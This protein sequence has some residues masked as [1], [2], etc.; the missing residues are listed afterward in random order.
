MPP[1]AP[2]PPPN[3]AGDDDDIIEL[4]EIVEKGTLG[5]SEDDD[6]FSLDDN[7]V[8]ISF[9]QELEELFSEDDEDAPRAA[10]AGPKAMDADAMD[11]DAMDMGALGLDDDA[12]LGETMDFSGPSKTEDEDEGEELLGLD[13][14]TVDENTG[15]DFDAALDELSA[16][17][18]AGAEAFGEQEIDLDSTLAFDEDLEAKLG[19]A[20][21]E[22]DSDELDLDAALA[23]LDQ[24]DM[25]QG[26]V[27]QAGMDQDDE[28][29]DLG[30][31][32]LDLD[33][34]MAMTED[35]A[36][37]LAG[38][39]MGFELDDDEE[40]AATVREDDMEHDLL[41]EIEDDA[42]GL[43]MDLDGGLDMDGAGSGSGPAIPDL[44]QLT[45]LS[46]GEGFTLEL[47]DEDGGLDIPLMDEEE[48]SL[49]ESLNQSIDEPMDEDESIDE[50][51]EMPEGAG[52]DL[53]ADDE[54]LLQE[55]ESEELLNLPEDEEEEAGEA[56]F[57]ADE[58]DIDISELDELIDELDL[59]GA[60]E[61]LQATDAP[62]TQHEVESLIKERNAAAVSAA[63]PAQ[64]LSDILER[65]EALEARLG[66]G[67]PGQ[68][69]G[70][71]VEEKISEALSEGSP[72][73]ASITQ[74]LAQEMGAIVQQAV[75]SLEERIVT[76]AELDGLK[77]S[78]GKELAAQMEKS[79]PEVAARIL[80]EEIEHL[81]GDLLAD[82]E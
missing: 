2:P 34:T 41:A 65:L 70:Q 45:D 29:G 37:E 64:D 31:G 28:D 6:L 33:A 56:A 58:E 74:S 20:E 26:G 30:I 16:E 25:D 54:D 66:E 12:D 62:V 19:M 15:L 73:L 22:G 81:A 46:G 82:E 23:G 10:G 47:G 4:T 77:D 3:Q 38:S 8:D 49:D 18:E 60:G 71:D 1:N 9:E 17:P 68:G 24:V 5:D 75:A 39:G 72:V 52:R 69:A 7:D 59:P 13:D 35:L 11:E 27:S 76:K 36:E 14:D 63:A 21:D 42:A 40:M 48:S 32:E 53:L 51:L 80:R 79:V 78:L 50:P 57:D 43:D 55:G 44:D 61:E 67:A